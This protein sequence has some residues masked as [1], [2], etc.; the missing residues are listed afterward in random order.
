LAA[1]TGATFI[2]DDLSMSLEK[3]GLDNLG[4]AE[5]VV[6]GKDSAT[7]VTSSKYKGAIQK[8]IEAIKTAARRAS[9]EFDQEKLMERATS[10]GGGIARIKVGAATETELRE[11]KLRYEDALNAVKSAIDMGVVPGGGSTLLHI[12]QDDKLI[13]SLKKKR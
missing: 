6:C 11:K 13:Q 10:L 8:R 12:A 7:F 2:S 9:T 4:F 1:A 3:V 5:R